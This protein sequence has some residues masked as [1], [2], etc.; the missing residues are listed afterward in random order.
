M[1]TYNGAAI[2]P[3][4]FDAFK[5]FVIN[6]KTRFGA[7]AWAA[8]LEQS[9]HAADA[10]RHHM[11]AYLMWTDGIGLEVRSLDP[12]VFE[13]LRPRV[14]VC[15]AKLGTTSPHSA[16]CHGAHPIHPILR[17]SI[18]R[19]PFGSKE[20]CRG[21]VPG[22]ADEQCAAACPEGVGESERRGG[23]PGT[24]R[25]EGNIRYQSTDAGL[26][27]ARSDAT[28]QDQRLPQERTCAESRHGERPRA[29]G[30][31]TDSMGIPGGFWS[32]STDSGFRTAANV[33][34]NVTRGRIQA[35]P[36]HPF[37][38][39]KGGEEGP[40]CAS[41]L[42]LEFYPTGKFRLQALLCRGGV[43]SN[44]G[45]SRRASKQGWKP[46][47][48]RPNTKTMPATSPATCR[49]SCCMR[50]QFLGSVDVRLRTA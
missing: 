40:G 34:E 4:S 10:G 45:R 30:F 12:F 26:G 23:V 28:L 38:I 46:T 49:R 18:P 20:R 42:F 37:I 5:T 24:G 39:L 7:R 8:C 41:C 43:R 3:T 13:G 9:L 33:W 47:I 32:H 15:T 22:R 16:A 17:D 27:G 2:A 11:H 6:L 50:R 44:Q 48:R 25:R 14:D 19:W 36:V 1:L 31:R 21:S 29:D 35:S